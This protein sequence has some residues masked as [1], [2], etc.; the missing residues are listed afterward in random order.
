[1]NILSIIESL[2]AGGGA[3]M[4]LSDLVIGLP[5]HSHVVWHFS[6]LNQKAADR[7]LI[8]RMTDHGVPVR[9]VDWRAV[10]TRDVRIRSL[11]GF[12]PDVVM[13][14]WWK[15]EPWAPWQ[16]EARLT[17]RPRFVSILH[18]SR[19]SLSPGYDRYVG[20]ARFQVARF[21]FL[22][23][24]N[25]R[26]IP[27][28]VDLTR[29]RSPSRAS[30]SKLG[31]PLV[32]GTMAGLRVEKVPLSLIEDAVAWNVPH[33][34]W[35]IAGTGIFREE[36]EAQAARLAQGKFRFL[37]LLPRRSVPRFLSG[38]DVLCHPVH[39]QVLDCNPIGVMEALAAGVPVVAE[40]RGGLPEIIDHGVNGLLASS[41]DE[42][43][44]LLRRLAGDRALVRRLAHEARE[45]A[46]RFDRPIQLAAYRKLLAEF[47][48]ELALLDEQAVAVGSRS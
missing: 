41:S 33:A 47:E 28:A 15:N 18:S 19:M 20:V 16:T 42:V 29:Y 46:R 9:D 35:Q 27:N 3:E 23:E 5:E 10:S 36:F 12:E 30:R 34:Q 1:M 11:D 22:A 44:E 17:G 38:L 40:A 45:S 37:G 32:I 43:G 2:G 21:P 6:R 39:P 13:I 14:H 26:V 7:P 24:E 48:P 25:V 31:E 8:R 4:A